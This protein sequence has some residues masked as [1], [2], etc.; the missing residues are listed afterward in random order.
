MK[1]VTED[2][3][4]FIQENGGNARDALNVTLA[5][6]EE[7]T[8][9]YGGADDLLKAK[10]VAYWLKSILDNMRD[11]LIHTPYGSEYIYKFV[12]DKYMINYAQ[13]E[14]DTFMDSLKERGW[15]E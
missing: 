3:D 6:L 15:L 5:K 9:L 7:A 13:Q 10:N 14:L 1:T 11:E 12:G 8:L 2:I 4:K